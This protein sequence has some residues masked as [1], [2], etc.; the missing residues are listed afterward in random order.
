[1][2]TNN[3]H[4]TLTGADGVV[5]HSALHFADAGLRENFTQNML[6]GNTEQA[7]VTIELGS[8]I[9]QLLERV[10]NGAAS[11]KTPET[12]LDLGMDTHTALVLIASVY[13]LGASTQEQLAAGTIPDEHIEEAKLVVS[14]YQHTG[15][16]L[17]AWIRGTDPTG[18][19]AYVAGMSGQD[20]IDKR[21]AVFNDLLGALSAP[22][23][24]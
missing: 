9:A 16:T 19:A 20:I 5:I 3:E 2:T 4:L 11:A 18:T 14:N 23:L 1:M 7:M 17:S 6:E 24:N 15:A 12:A 8:N 21:K 13:A 10:H 22:T